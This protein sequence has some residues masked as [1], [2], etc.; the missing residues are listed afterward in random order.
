[1]VSTNSHKAKPDTSALPHQLSKSEIASLRHE[2]QQSLEE[3]RQHQKL[4]EAKQRKA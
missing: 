2:M 1:M 3:M 4:R